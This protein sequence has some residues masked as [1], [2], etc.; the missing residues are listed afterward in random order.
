MA[1]GVEIRAAALWDFPAMW[2]ILEPVI[3]A[4]ETYML[5]RDMGAA[6]ALGYWMRPEREVFVAEAEGRV[7]GT[8]YLRANQQGGGGH[9][10]NCGYMTARE[11]MGRGVGRAMAAHSLEVARARGFRA[12]QFNAVVSSNRRAVALWES[13]GFT[14][15]CRLPG[16]FAHPREG[17]VDALVMFR[18]L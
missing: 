2:A 9:V 3:R 6:E 11:A 14:T 8:Y 15:L 5:P 12:M 13:F 4:G 1:P 7:V 10:A 17:F 16:A 18:E